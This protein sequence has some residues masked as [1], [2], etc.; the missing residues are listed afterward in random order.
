MTSILRPAA[1][2]IL[3]LSACG[4]SVYYA[5][6]GPVRPPL[7]PDAPVTVFLMNRPEQPYE[8]L[9][10]VEVRGASLPP[11]I[12]KAQK[13]ARRRGANA[14]MLMSSALAVETRESTQKLETKDADGKVI[15]TR[16][17][18]V[19]STMTTEIDRFVALWIEPR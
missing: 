13:E 15:Q 4:P 19:T 1:I 16:E 3:L 2:L 17:V 14:L 8:E 6:T 11:R 18:P 5:R 12:E 10:L 7:P 9:G